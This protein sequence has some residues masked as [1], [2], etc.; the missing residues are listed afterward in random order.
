MILS[1]QGVQVKQNAEYRP[2]DSTLIYKYSNK[3]ENQFQ[4]INYVDQ[5]TSR[6]LSTAPTHIEQMHTTTTTAKYQPFQSL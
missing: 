2:I 3:P 6:A 5:G 4:H 1:Q